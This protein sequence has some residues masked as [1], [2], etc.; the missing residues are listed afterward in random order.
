[1]SKMA[2]IW[3]TSVALLVLVAG[4]VLG[5][6]FVDVSRRAGVADDGLGKGVAVK[7]GQFVEFTE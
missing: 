1:M 7:A 6:E 4:L 3:L 2:G 5:Q